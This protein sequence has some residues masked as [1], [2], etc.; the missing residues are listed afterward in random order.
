MANR[1]KL[2]PIAAAAVFLTGCSAMQAANNTE[3]DAVLVGGDFKGAALIAESRLGLKPAEDGS[4]PDVAGSAGSVLNHLEAGEAWR[5]AGESQRS[6]AHYDFAEQA[7]QAVELQGTASEATK[8]VGATLVNDMLL[9]YK[10][11]PAEAV[12]VNYHKAITF[13]HEGDIDNARVE[14][15]R[16]EDR[17]RRSVERYEREIAEAQAETSGR[18]GSDDATMG[19][20]TTGLGMNEWSPYDGFVMPQA[21]YLH[22]LFLA[23]SGDTADQSSAIELLERVAGLE[24]GN[25]VVAEDLRNLKAGDICPTKDCVWFLADEG[26]GPV[27]EEFRMDIPIVTMSGLVTASFA[28][29]KLVSRQ[30]SPTDYVS[31]RSG[32]S[33]ISE[34]TLANMDRV[35]QSEF[36]KRTPAVITRAVVG[37]TA[38]AIA[39]N[40]LNKH[41]GPLAGL[42]GSL[43]NI[44]I[45]GADVRSWR[46]TPGTT[47]LAQIRKNGNPVF[48]S[49]AG[50]TQEMSLP[51]AGMQIVYVKQ[52]NIGTPALV[53]VLEIDRNMAVAAARDRAAARAQALA[54]AQPAPAESVTSPVVIPTSTDAEADALMDSVPQ[55]GASIQPINTFTSIQ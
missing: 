35:V 53:N 1:F 6:L 12:L 26:Q 52:P 31:L 3:M 51:S 32:D 48:L 54:A 44:A 43:F 10:P 19:Q 38:R 23:T 47:Q 22:A 27:L 33:V 17:I 50:W 15:N 34:Y 21:T 39:Q 28:I 14:L 55:Q 2:A 42:A 46:S 9:D 7:L 30:S 24:P 13:W 49:S 25:S 41:A 45:T 20:V 36:K 4:L 11:S 18:E 40:E 8:Q 5:L 37:A 16:A 29:P